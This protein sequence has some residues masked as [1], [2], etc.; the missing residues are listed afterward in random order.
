VKSVIESYVVVFML[1]H[2]VTYIYIYII[3]RDGY[4]YVAV[5]QE[6]LELLFLIMNDG[7]FPFLLYASG[8]FPDKKMDSTVKRKLS[9]G[10][11]LWS[12]GRTFCYMWTI[13]CKEYDTQCV[14][15]GQRNL[16]FKNLFGMITE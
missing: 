12:Y 13:M 3:Y 10:T 5:L 1:L 2:S 16:I 8:I 7:Q 6:C 4:T 9:L 15:Q 11:F 14:C